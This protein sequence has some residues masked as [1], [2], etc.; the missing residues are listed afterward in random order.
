VHIKST[1]LHSPWVC[2][3]IKGLFYFFELLF[4]PFI[5]L[6][7][8]VSR[9]KKK[10]ID[11]GLGPEPL[12]NNVY[13]KQALVKYGYTAETFV[14]QV[15]TTTNC[16]DLI[17]DDLLNLSY[18][19]FRKIFKKIFLRFQGLI[20][21]VFFVWRY[22]CIYIYFNGGPLNLFQS[23][24]RFLEPH[25]YK[26]AKV[27]VVVMPYGGDVQDLLRTPHL[28]FRHVMSQQ[29]PNARFRRRK[30]QVNIDMWSCFAD[31]LIIGW[32]A[33]F[34]IEGM[35]MGK[36]VLCYLKDEFKNLYID[37]GLVGRDEIPIVNCNKNNVKEKIRELACDRK[38]TQAIEERS[39]AFVEKHH[40]LEA[41]GKVFDRIN[42]QIG[43]LPSQEKSYG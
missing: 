21:F 9:W 24:Y 16:F 27:K 28:L 18:L 22:R 34:A 25:F 29:Y 42:R 7:I 36:P 40:S 10:S 33:M 23:L 4:L 31:Q 5:L 2:C 3:L 32:Y 13:H 11:I 26:L 19:P 1:I 15:Y 8:L 20:L 6:I 38:K 12:I 41:V 39:R 30:V 43:V 14:G 17:F 35:A 37:V